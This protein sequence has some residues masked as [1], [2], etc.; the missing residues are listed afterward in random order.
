MQ[1]LFEAT[2]CLRA[3]AHYH[4]EDIVTAGGASAFVRLLKN[5]RHDSIR[6]QASAALR[7]L[8]FDHSGHRQQLASE[9]A[10]PALVQ[11]F[12]GAADEVSNTV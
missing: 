6:E 12:D 1:V 5:F 10:V 4:A 9:G 7:S 11:M 3:I 2:S 8:G